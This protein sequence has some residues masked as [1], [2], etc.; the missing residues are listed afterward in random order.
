MSLLVL[1]RYILD[2]CRDLL[3]VSLGLL[4]GRYPIALALPPSDVGLHL[5]DPTVLLLHLVAELALSVYIDGVIDELQ[6]ARLPRPVLLVALLSEVSPLPVAA[7][8][9]C[10]FEVTH[11]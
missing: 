1:V 6:A 7:V 9:A 10:L 3:Y 5:G 8:P 2:L 11:G 4:N